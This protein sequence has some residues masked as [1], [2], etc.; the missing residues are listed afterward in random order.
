MSKR[1]VALAFSC[2]GLLATAGHTQTITFVDEQGAPATTLLYDG[3]A[4]VRVTDAAA[5]TGPGRDEVTAV[6]TSDLGGES[7]SVALFE[8][9]PG[10]GVFEGLVDL[11]HLGAP[12]APGLATAISYGPP[13]VAD[14]LH[15]T[16]PL[17]GATAVAGL[18]EGRISFFDAWGRESASFV[19][20]DTVGVRVRTNQGVPELRGYE[21]V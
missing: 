14:T 2:L 21:M 13:R 1:L 10:P 6:V 7:E 3:P 17:N 19:A 9:G 11:V 20:G 15:A 5:N 4:R 18:I 12:G 16:Y 8:T